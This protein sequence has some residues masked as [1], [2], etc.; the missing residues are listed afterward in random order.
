MEKC[1]ENNKMGFDTSMPLY[2]QSTEHDSAISEED[3]QQEQPIPKVIEE[4]RKYVED[5][6]SR[7]KSKY[8]SKR[9]QIDQ[10]NV[11]FLMPNDQSDSD[12][13]IDTDY[14]FDFNSSEEEQREFELHNE[15]TK[16]ISTVS[17]SLSKH[18]T[19]YLSKVEMAKMKAQQAQ[20][21]ITPIES[22]NIGHKLLQKMGWSQGK[23]LGINDNGLLEPIKASRESEAAAQSSDIFD[24][25]TYQNKNAGLG[26][27]NNRNT[28][29]SDFLAQGQDSGENSGGNLENSNNSNYQDFSQSI[30]NF[31]E[32]NKMKR[33][34]MYDLKRARQSLRRQT[35]EFDKK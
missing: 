16:V 23:R 6:Q 32:L 3:S 26:V 8:K 27:N 35:N 12:S 14:L 34:Q 1:F 13:E 33:N 7:K 15:T 29:E 5:V 28:I 31:R 10:M 20:K 2:P 21:S 24:Q 17:K 11:K 30:Q 25:A 9:E 18:H 22:D 4:C 19:N